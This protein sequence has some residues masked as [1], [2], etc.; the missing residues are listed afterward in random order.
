MPT[1]LKPLLAISITLLV[2]SIGLACYMSGPMNLISRPQRGA[3]VGYPILDA[4][5]GG[6]T[7]E[8]VDR[9]L[10]VWT[11][12]QISTYRELHLGPDMLY[13]WVYTGFFFATAIVLFK[14]AFPA[15]TLWPLL[16]ILPLLNLIADYTENYLISFVILPAGSPSDAGTVAWA[17]RATCAKWVLVLLNALALI[18]G[19]GLVCLRARRK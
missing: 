2:V 17:S 8:D 9:R 3:Q 1:T 4:C 19:I 16:L 10:E 6:Y 12:D 15:R 11:A 13:P 5:F 7:N 14:S 18:I